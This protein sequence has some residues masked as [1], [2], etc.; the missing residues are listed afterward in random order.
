MTVKAEMT[1]LMNTQI[2]VSVAVF[3]NYSISC[4]IW[5]LIASLEMC[6]FTR[7]AQAHHHHIQEQ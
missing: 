1:Q 7:L 2:Q 4:L 3:S 5:Q 6:I